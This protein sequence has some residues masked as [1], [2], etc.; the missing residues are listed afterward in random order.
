MVNWFSQVVELISHRVLGNLNQLSF[1][2]AQNQLHWYTQDQIEE[3]MLLFPPSE[4][5]EILSAIYKM[6]FEG[7]VIIQL[8]EEL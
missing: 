2:I 7:S 5:D 1:E 4:I 8:E 3:D 6:D